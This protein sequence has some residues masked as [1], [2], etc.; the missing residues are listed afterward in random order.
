MTQ[1]D[2][3]RACL[4][5]VG[6]DGGGLVDHR[7]GGVGRSGLVGGGLGV[8]GGSLIGHIGDVSIITIG[9]VG[10]TLDSTIGKSNR[11][12][13]L[14]IAGAIGGL[15]GAEAGLGVVISHGV[16]VGVG[17]DLVSVDLSLVGGGVVSGGGV[18]GGGRGVHGAR[19]VSRAGQ[20][21]GDA[22]GKTSKD[23]KSI[24][25]RRMLIC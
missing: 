11:V 3:V 6:G 16:G 18:I 25:M 9:G 5:G 21:G 7:G 20:G 8:L 17:E 22:G 23:L 2:Q 12:G 1:H 4:A 15:I 10:D 13:A 19:G 14:D 24:G